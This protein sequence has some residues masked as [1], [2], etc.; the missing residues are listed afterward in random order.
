M[1]L[2]RMYT[3]KMQNSSDCKTFVKE[4]VHQAYVKKNCELSRRRKVGECFV[5]QKIVGRID[6]TVGNCAVMSISV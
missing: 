3:V 6:F 4:R 5:H 2:M 1:T